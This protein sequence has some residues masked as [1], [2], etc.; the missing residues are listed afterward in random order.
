MD[1]YADRPVL[2]WRASTLVTDPHTGRTSAVP[3]ER[4]ETITYRELWQRAQDV[5][6]G[7][8][9]VPFAPGDRLCM[10]GFNSADYTVV[11][12]A[13]MLAGAVTVPLQ[14][15]A[16]RSQLRPVVAEA[17]PTVIATGVEQLADA[18]E[19]AL[20]S[21]AGRVLVFAADLAVDE[22]RE[23][24]QVA[25]DR[26]AGSR[27]VLETVSDVAAR[28]AGR[29]LRTAPAAD[30]AL[31]L[32]I[33]TS[34][35]TGTPKGA[36]FTERHLRKGWRRTGWGRLD[37]LRYPAI[38]LN[39]LPM[40][41]IMGRALLYTTLSGGGTAYFPAA[42][43]LSTLLEDLALVRPTQL[44]LVPRVWE[45]LYGEFRSEVAR[46]SCGA[47]DDALAQVSADLRQ[48]L[49]GGRVI[50]AMSSSAPI[51]D[52]LKSWVESF[53]DLHVVESLGSTEAG[54]LCFDGVVMR[55][56]VLDYKLEDV[57][58]LGY[59]GTDRPHP[60]GELLVKTDAVFGGYFRQPDVTAAVFDP[61]GYFRTG[62]V[63]AE[64]G[65][66]QLKYVDRRNVVLQLAQGE[67][68]TLSRLE[69]LFADSPLVRQIY[70]YGNSLRSYL[71][72]GVVPTDEAL[73][74]QED[75]GPLIRASLREVADR[76]GLQPFEIPRDVVVVDTT[77]FTPEN[78]LL[79]GIRKLARPK[80]AE[81]YGA[82][83]EQRY[84]DLAQREA[85]ELRLLHD[86]SAR[87]PAVETV[88]PHC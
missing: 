71:L 24:L 64:L 61:D 45:M 51:S 26:I 87:T 40:S 31:R 34:G 55:P 74:R 1:G 77:P 25:R 39:F 33:Y 8:T 15:G 88:R 27:V 84:A 73:A 66:D 13:S 69:A 47:D 23:A 14:F 5:A 4:F 48:R 56:V 22:H 42:S 37:F 78:G 32:L 85:D 18:V 83:L 65:P 62:D 60:R 16:P 58:E 82:L 50:S 67:F 81:R 35:S 7:L 46:R 20:G 11:D 17:E 70:L 10:L 57:P 63:V 54:S 21:T 59:L 44:S 41:H 68:V 49:L 3:Q 76:A 80:L 53:L 72:A 52:A 12:L 38:T 28:R 9:D 86:E 19:L 30:N 29:P 43:D 2:G 79:T 75:L 6:V 36:M